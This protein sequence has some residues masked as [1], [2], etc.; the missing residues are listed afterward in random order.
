MAVAARDPKLDE[1]AELLCDHSRPLSEL[2]LRR[3]LRDVESRIARASDHQLTAELYN[4]QAIGHARLGQPKKALD[5]YRRALQRLREPTQARAATLCNQAGALLDVGRYQEAA[6]SSLEASKIPAGY[7][8]VTLVNLARALYLLGETDGALETFQEALRLADL[9]NPSHCFMM[10]SQ[11][12]ELGLDQDAIEL[13]ARFIVR[14]NGS[15]GDSRPA[16]EIVGTASDEDTAGLENVPALEATIRRRIAMAAELARLST[17]PT[18]EGDEAS[19][20]E[21]HDVYEATRRLREEALAHVL[22]G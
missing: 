18:A 14:R 10:A 8:H 20:G 15:A 4:L 2:E 22:L 3:L 1:Y 5:D 16:L 7:T 9:T 17:L 11:A 21:A 12:A 6:L 13:F 19:S